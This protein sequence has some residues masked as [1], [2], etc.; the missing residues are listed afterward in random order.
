MQVQLQPLNHVSEI[1]R[2]ET[3]DIFG[4]TGRPRAESEGG[5]RR[6]QTP[7]APCRAPQT[8]RGAVPVSGTYGFQHPRCRRGATLKA[9]TDVVGV[10]PG[11]VLKQHLSGF[12][13]PGQRLQKVL[14]LVS[15]ATTGQNTN[16]KCVFRTTDGA[17]RVPAARA[18]VAVV[19]NDL[20]LSTA[21]IKAGGLHLPAQPELIRN[22][23]PSTAPPDTIINRHQF[24]AAAPRV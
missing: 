7:L 17:F 1:G 18:G 3:H 19:S 22:V 23:P 9:L 10:G 5:R 6:L 11:P 20:F 13:G 4:D 14:H 15:G 24:T 2:V 8:R 21:A 12:A 16:K